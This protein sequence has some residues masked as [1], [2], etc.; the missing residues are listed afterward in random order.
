MVTATV[1]V[2]PIADRDRALACLTLAFATD[3]IMRW[4]WPGAQRYSA[5]FPPTADAFG[6]GAL[7]SGTAYALEGY[8]G[9]ALWKPPGAAGPDEERLMA[10]MAE[11]IE[12]Q[13]L[14]DLGQVLDRMGEIHPTADHWYLPLIGVDPIAQGRG[15]GSALLAD[16]TAK[17]DSDGLP[18]YLEATS[19]RSRDLY[20]RHGFD[21]VE[22]IQA[23]ASPPMWAMLREP[24]S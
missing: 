1:D 24:R 9:V 14:A 23:G 22:V 15:L 20:A 3:P 13:V 4:A 7:D 2:I 16:M 17:C 11:S 18:A 8:L 21:T 6:G 5:Y 19:P 12:D 10:L